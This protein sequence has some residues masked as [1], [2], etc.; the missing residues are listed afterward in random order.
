M[1]QTLIAKMPTLPWKPQQYN[2]CC[3]SEVKEQNSA[4]IMIN[5]KVLKQKPKHAIPETTYYSTG[6][7][8]YFKAFYK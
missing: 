7:E 3:P 5:F 6:T 4:N 2:L 1:T 8:N